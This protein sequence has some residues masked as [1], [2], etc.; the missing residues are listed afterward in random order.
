[1]VDV[2]EVRSV[3]VREEVSP[4]PH[5][6]RV[7]GEVPDHRPD[8]RP[9]PTTSLLLRAGSLAAPM[10]FVEE[11]TSSAPEPGR[12]ESQRHPWFY[13]FVLAP[14]SLTIYYRMFGLITDV[15]L[16]LNLR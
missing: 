2:S 14:C 3:K 9:R 1:M 6:R 10:D 13:A 5:R 7:R 16:L 15:A 4:D 11:R 12:R 8:R